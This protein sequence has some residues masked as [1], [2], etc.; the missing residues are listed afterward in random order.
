MFAYVQLTDEKASTIEPITVLVPE[1][2]GV[3]LD[4]AEGILRDAG[5]EP[6]A[7]AVANPDVEP[8]IVYEQ[9]PTPDQVVEDGSKVI[10][11]YSPDEGTVLVEMPNLE[12]LPIDDALAKVE[13]LGL[14]VGKVTTE[15][16]QSRRPSPRHGS[17]SSRRHE[18]RRWPR[19]RTSH[20]WSQSPLIR[21]RCRMSS[22]CSDADAEQ[23]LKDLGFK[24]EVIEEVND[25]VEVGHVMRSEPGRG[26][27]LDPES[28]VVIVISLG[29]E[30][31]VV[32]D[33]EGFT[34]NQARQ[35]LQDLEL[36]AK[37]GVPIDLPA[38][39]PRDG[40]VVLQNPEQGIQGRQGHDRHG[41]RRQ[42]RR[43]SATTVAATT[44]S[45]STSTTTHDD[46]DHHHHHDDNDSAPQRRNSAGW[47][48][49]PRVL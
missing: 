17:W 38:G 18:T 4:A 1:V 23:A 14:D 15:E 30:Q 31:V 13:A 43:R 37:V 20:S 27:L 12:G 32:P 22:R 42:G 7:Q 2:R 28:K 19:T 9:D 26:E 29:K 8:N 21:S 40:T 36:K 24:V 25:A 49:G 39:D 47:S 45:T 48:T 11:T 3:T 35:A 46:D 5:L 41:P 16:R 6:E 44:S 33:L 34:E 10:I